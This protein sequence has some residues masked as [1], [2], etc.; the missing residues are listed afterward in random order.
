MAMGRQ[1]GYMQ[2]GCSPTMPCNHD[3][4][5]YLYLTHALPKDLASR[6]L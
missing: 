4:V 6:I 5:W 3:W 2:E 1:V